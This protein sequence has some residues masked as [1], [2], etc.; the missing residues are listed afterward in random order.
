MH[1]HLRTDWIRH[2]RKLRIDQ[3]TIPEEIKRLDVQDHRVFEQMVM[4]RPTETIARNTGLS[5]ED[6][7]RAQSRVTHAL[8]ANGNLHMILRDPEG[9]I[10]EHTERTAASSLKPQALPIQQT[11]DRI[12]EAICGL[13]RELPTPQQILLDMV[14]DKELD[15][16]TIL[17]QC[18]SLNIE[19]PVRPRNNNITIH[20]IY[21]S[22]DAIL[23]KLG[24]Q[25]Q[26]THPALL[27]DASNWLERDAPSAR[28]VSEKGLKAMLK[29]MGIAPMPPH[30]ETERRASNM[31]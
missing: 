22:V 11:V 16:K 17:A 23:N 1:G 2:R 10:D 20:T 30:A 28:S 8:M 25:L 19:L 29:N 31:D 18:L 4:Q 7:E 6:T 12:W 13:I 24:K 5:V 9:A 26:D 14:F 21:Q 27:R 15:A 3:I